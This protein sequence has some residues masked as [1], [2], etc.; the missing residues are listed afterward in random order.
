MVWRKSLEVIWRKVCISCLI[1]E[2]AWDDR[3]SMWHWFIF[4][5]A[6]RA[7]I[8]FWMIGPWL[9]SNS[10]IVFTFTLPTR[11]NYSCKT[12]GWWKFSQKCIFNRIFNWLLKWPFSIS[13]F[14]AMKK[15]FI[16]KLT[17]CER[18]KTTWLK[19]GH[20]N[21]KDVQELIYRMDNVLRRSAMHIS[22]YGH[23]YCRVWKLVSAGGIN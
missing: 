16:V 6:H 14:L 17:C 23:Y 19:L 2:R 1:M 12:S 15:S 4:A 20:R 8:L 10:S 7:C 13:S 22:I 9:W 5:L 18:Q 3:E 21:L 11:I